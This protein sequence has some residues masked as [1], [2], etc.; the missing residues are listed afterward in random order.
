MK[1][2]WHQKTPT[3]STCTSLVSRGWVANNILK[4]IQPDEDLL[5]Y[6]VSVGEIFI[7]SAPDLNAFI[8]FLQRI[9]HADETDTL[10]VQFISFFLSS[11]ASLL[12]IWSYSAEETF[13]SHS[14][15]KKIQWM[16]RA[17]IY[18]LNKI[19]QYIYSFLHSQLP[20]D[21]IRFICKGL[22]CR[23]DRATSKAPGQSSVLQ[24]QECDIGI[25]RMCQWP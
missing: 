13:N 5:Q 20:S 16:D 11:V 4:L 6:N 23:S 15:D 10:P 14:F 7:L 24:C 8:C 2:T 21:Q 1:Q 12:D 18:V 17:C 25:A 3:R 19:I 9:K 22:S